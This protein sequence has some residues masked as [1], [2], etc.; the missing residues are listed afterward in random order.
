MTLLHLLLG[1]C[2]TTPP[3]MAII[4]AGK[5][6][7]AVGIIVGL[8]VGLGSGG[9]GLYTFKLTADYLLRSYE[10]RM[11]GIVRDMIDYA[12]FICFGIVTLTAGG[13]AAF[14]TKFIIRYVAA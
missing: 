9:L 11:H 2:F 7:G 4:F 10:R 5:S 13:L 3:A 6:A 1:I 12:I 8:L 14:M